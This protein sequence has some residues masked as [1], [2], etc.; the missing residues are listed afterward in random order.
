MKTTTCFFIDIDGVLQTD[1]AYHAYSMDT[2]SPRD[3]ML[4][5]D[6][7]GIK[8]I[9]RLA[10]DYNAEIVISST[11]RNHE[12]T[13]QVQTILR[14]H[15][16]RAPFHIEWKTPNSWKRPRGHEIQQ[17][18]DEHGKD[19]Q[20]FL[21]LDDNSDMTEYQKDHYF[22]QTDTYDGFLFSHYLEAKKK[23][24]KQLNIP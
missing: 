10:A 1:R 9:D 17:W 3:L 11:W 14:T 19:Y 2:I 24:E 4:T 20:A 5:L 7:I 13:S 22:V 6:P 12:R 21:I 18:I 15:G 23:L 8:L 16:F